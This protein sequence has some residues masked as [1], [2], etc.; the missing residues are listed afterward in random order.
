MTV[1]A[2]ENPAPHRYAIGNGSKAAFS[3]FFDKNRFVFE[4]CPKLRL[5]TFYNVFFGDIF[6]FFIFIFFFG[7]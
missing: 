6:L 1:K 3:A 2:W 4:L 7:H 5:P